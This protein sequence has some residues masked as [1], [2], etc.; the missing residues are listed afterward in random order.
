MPSQTKRKA[1]SALELEVKR[2]ETVMN[3]IADEFVCPIAGELPVD[4]VQAEDGKIYE[5]AAITK[6]LARAQRSPTTNLAM[7]SNLSPATQVRNIIAQLVESGSI[8]GD[9]AT[10]WKKKLADEKALKDCRTKAEE[11]DAEGR[12]PP[13]ARRA[14]KEQRPTE[15]CGSSS[16]GRC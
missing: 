9:K 7:G 10:A 8:E 11:G 12:C 16:A 15:P 6:W 1:E 5:R 13:M 2:V 3:S 14:S 4:P